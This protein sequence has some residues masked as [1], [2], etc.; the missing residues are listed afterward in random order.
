MAARAD[1]WSVL[2]LISAAV[3]LWLSYQYWRKK[4]AGAESGAAWFW[5]G[6]MA[7]A[8]VCGVILAAITSIGGDF[9]RY[10]LPLY[11]LALAAAS[12]GISRLPARVWRTVGLVGAVLAV[13]VIQSRSLGVEPL[14]AP[15]HIEVER[16]LD[17][18]LNAGGTSRAWLLTHTRPQD[19]IVSV[20]GQALHY[21]LQRPVVSIIGP[22]YSAHPED[23]QVL[24]A[25][26]KQFRSRYL[27]VFPGMDAPEQNDNPFLAGLANGS[28]L[29][30]WLHNA[31]QGQSV[32]IWECGQC[33]N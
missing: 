8:Y 1:L 19:V 28:R 18:P 7:T 6:A 25:L 5:L 16:T 12:A 27:I 2:F 26:M 11:P 3:L 14:V 30:E 9:T 20:N 4:S 23:E 13:F 22:Q 24:H 15:P 21:L 17:Q 10:Y 29:P 32:S 31:A 33:V